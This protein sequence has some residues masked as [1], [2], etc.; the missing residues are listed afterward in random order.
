MSPVSPKPCNSST[1]GPAPPTRTC[2]VPPVTA[3]SRA[4]K[5][6]E[7]GFTSATAQVAT[8]PTSAAAQKHA[9]TG[10]EGLRRDRLS[11]CVM[12]GSHCTLFPLTD[13]RIGALGDGAWRFYRSGR[14]SRDARLSGRERLQ[15]ALHREVPPAHPDRPGL[16]IGRFGRPSLTRDPMHRD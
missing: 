13:A 11:V 10:D 14:R 16:V 3:M 15:V 6:A 5:L 12:R 1:A 8:V 4:L 7:K 2:N 9:R